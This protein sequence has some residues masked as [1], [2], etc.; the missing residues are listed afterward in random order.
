[1]RHLEYNDDK[2]G[3]HALVYWWY[4]LKMSRL[5][6]KLK[7]AIYPHTIGPG[8]R[9]YHVGAYTHVGPNVHIGENC[10]M[11]SGVV[12][13]NKTEEEDNS[14]VIVGNNV[15]FG[16]DCKIIGSVKI[17]NNVKIGANA[18]VTKNIPDNAIVAGVPAKIIGY[19]D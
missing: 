7:I 11:V 15:Y 8:F 5:Q 16:I 9:L 1:M 6:F 12:F 3:L 2:G 14:P 4:R 17:G 10:T 19:N 13:G 18:V